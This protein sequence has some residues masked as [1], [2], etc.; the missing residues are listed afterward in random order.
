MQAMFHM[1][2]VSYCD[3]LSKMS[4]SMPWLDVYLTVDLECL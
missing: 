4:E 1:L 2:M 3:P